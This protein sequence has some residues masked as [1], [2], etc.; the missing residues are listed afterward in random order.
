MEYY[1]ILIIIFFI[2]LWIFHD[3]YVK[4]DSS[5]DFTKLQGTV[6]NIEKINPLKD[7][8]N[9]PD[10]KFIINGFSEEKGALLKQVIEELS[11][12]GTP[13]LYWRGQ[14]NGWVLSIIEDEAQC[15]SFILT[16]EKIF[17]QTWSR[18]Y[19]FQSSGTGYDFEEL[20]IESKESIINFVRMLKQKMS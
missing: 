6:E 3:K 10:I 13:G 12:I 9:K 1:A 19:N 4:S 5:K 14:T 15:G 11:K 18:N 17:G 2:L 7:S 8:N 20:P 16:K